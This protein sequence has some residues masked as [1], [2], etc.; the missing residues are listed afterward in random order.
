[1]FDSADGGCDMYNYANI[2]LS[3]WRPTPDTGL[4]WKTG[5]VPNISEIL[6]NPEMEYTN[7]Y[8]TENCIATW[9]ALEP[10]RENYN[11][12][13]IMDAAKR[14]DSNKSKFISW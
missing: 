11:L 10:K 13:I 12:D 1:M 4:L 7:I 5:M 14:A 3:K 8:R 9:K 2:D 6:E